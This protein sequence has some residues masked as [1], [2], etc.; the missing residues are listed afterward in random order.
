MITANG[1]SLME[2]YEIWGRKEWGKGKRRKVA[3]NIATHDA[4]KS[5]RKVLIEGGYEDCIICRTQKA[6]APGLEIG[7]KPPTGVQ[8]SS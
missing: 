4:A 8:R 1:E 7:R 6:Y 5:L 3:Y 2:K